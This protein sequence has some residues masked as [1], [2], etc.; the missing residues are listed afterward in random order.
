MMSLKELNR[1]RRIHWIERILIPVGL[2]IIGVLCLCFYVS[3]RGD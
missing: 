3:F 2:T 1:A